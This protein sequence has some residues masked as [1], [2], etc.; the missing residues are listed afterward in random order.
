MSSPFLLQEKHQLAIMWNDRVEMCLREKCGKRYNFSGN[1][2]VSFTL[3]LRINFDA[4]NLVFECRRS[5][6]N[7]L[8]IEI[9][10]MNETVDEPS[11]TNPLHLYIY[12]CNVKF[13]VMARSQ[14]KEPGDYELPYMVN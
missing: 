5:F 7:D 12:K 13:Y 4:K 2:K 11:L 8:L 10:Q 3:N 14:M 9:K 1:S 6:S